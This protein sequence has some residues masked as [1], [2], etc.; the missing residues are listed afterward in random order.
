MARRD[1]S[2]ALEYIQDINIIYPNLLKMYGAANRA[3]S[4]EGFDPDIIRMALSVYSSQHPDVKVLR[5]A[6]LNPNQVAQIGMDSGL[7]L[8]DNFDILNKL[9]GKDE[10]SHAID[11]L[12]TEPEDH[13]IGDFKDIPNETPSAIPLDHNL[14]DNF[15]DI[16]LDALNHLSDYLDINANVSEDDIKEFLQEFGIA[17]QAIDRLNQALFKTAAGYPDNNA[18]WRTLGQ[19]LL[20]RIQDPDR[21]KII[22][23]QNGA[24]EEEA[25][26]ALVPGKDESLEDTTPSSPL[27]GSEE[28]FDPNSM[29]PEGDGGGLPDIPGMDVEDG[30]FFGQDPEGENPTQPSLVNENGQDVIEMNEMDPNSL[31]AQAQKIV[32]SDPQMSK[33]ELLAIL[34]EKGADP[35][36]AIQVA[37]NLIIQEDDSIQPGTIV[38]TPDSKV[39]AVSAVWDTLFGKMASV[40]FGNNRIAEYIFEDLQ[41]TN[42]AFVVD[43]SNDLLDRVSSFADETKLE[44]G[45]LKERIAKAE[46]LIREISHELMSQSKKISSTYARLLVDYRDLFKEEVTRLK[47]GQVSFM[48]QDEKDYINSRPKY[49]FMAGVVAGNEMG[50]GGAEGFLMAAE[51][52]EAHLAS[53]DW[54]KEVISGAVDFVSGIHPRL[55]GDVTQVHR[56]ATDH[57]APKIAYFSLEKGQQLLSKFLEN[58]EVARRRM[59]I[60]HRQATVPGEVRVDK[61]FENIPEDLLEEGWLM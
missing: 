2:A 31:D 1:L 55:I 30:D 46:K 50:P 36:E 11:G 45:D 41:K 44:Q 27:D 21:I 39:G 17:N 59:T 4:Q 22:L 12:S 60:E 19:E 58:V 20:K 3:L 52:V 25:A 37:D 35:E 29:G 15:S 40:E 47:Q 38:R 5:T 42:D 61:I 49:K 16:P 28:G 48:S 26:A 57:F 43:S 33:D 54:N 7:S 9:F 6:K 34:K 14:E 56:M 32:G 8:E 23:E 53:I 13:P 10:A 18:D 51:E 24:T